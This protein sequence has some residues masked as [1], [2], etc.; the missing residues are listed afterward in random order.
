M[1]SSSQA[2][3]HR[4]GKEYENLSPSV[5][6]LT[7]AALNVSQE[8]VDLKLKFLKKQTSCRFSNTCCPTHYCCL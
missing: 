7:E 3:H 8:G 4:Y 1:F 2:K 6:S 5:L